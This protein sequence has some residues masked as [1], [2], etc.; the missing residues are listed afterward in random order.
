MNIESEEYR[1]FRDTDINEV[2]PDFEIIN[3]KRVELLVEGRNIKPFVGTYKGLINAIKFYGYDN[4]KIKEYWLNIDDTSPNYGKYKTTEVRDIFDDDVDFNDSNFQL[5][6]KVFKKTSLFSLVYRL[7]QLTG[8]VDK[9]EIPETEETS[10]FTLDEIL[11]KLYGLKN[12][13]MKKW[14]G[15]NSRILDI[16]GEADYFGKIEQ[17][18][19]VDQNRIE[20]IDSGIH[21]SFEVLPGKKGYVQDL[22]KLE[23]LV[24]PGFTPYLIDPNLLA[25]SDITISE[26]ADALLGYFTNYNPNLDSVEQLPDKPGIPV[27]YPIVLKNTS[28]DITWDNAQI[29]YNELIST[30]NLLLDFSPENVGADDVFTIVDTESGEQVSYTAVFGD[31]SEDV[32]NGLFTEIQTQLSIDDGRPWSYYSIT[33]E[34]TSGSGNND[35]V[36]FRQIFT[37]SIPSTFSI[38]ATRSDFGSL[39]LLFTERKYSL[40]FE[41]ML[42]LTTSISYPSKYLRTIFTAYF[43]TTGSIILSSD[44]VA[45]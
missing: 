19:W 44:E 4:I 11:I 45:C 26:I 40:I 25:D 7:N 8:S 15:S 36:R 16:T 1:V 5:P 13:L 9:Y 2:L 34:D 28:F 20:K 23:D 43:L 18:V 14:L 41:R 21:P 17:N 29:T 33:K 30:G 38:I 6:N 24:F 3:N 27:G 22:R 37:E 35:T 39:S 12:V 10:E 42:F 31:T 32:V